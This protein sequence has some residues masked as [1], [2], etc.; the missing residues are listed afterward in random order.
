MSALMETAHAALRQS[1]YPKLLMFGDPGALVSPAFAARFAGELVD[2][3]LAPLGSGLHYLQEDHPDE[4]G[5]C[6][7]GWIAKC[8]RRVDRVEPAMEDA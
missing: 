7:A 3:E 8:E 4:I 2:C 6:V 1:L 5:R